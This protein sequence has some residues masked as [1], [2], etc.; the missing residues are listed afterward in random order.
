MWN[1]FSSAK[2]ALIRKGTEQALEPLEKQIG[3]LVAE[4]KAQPLKGW[5]TILVNFVIVAGTA[6]VSF[7]AGLDLE[8]DLGLTPTIATVGMAVINSIL[9]AITTGPVGSKL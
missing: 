9:R 7:L 4:Q 6:G 5:R 1:P 8:K 2:N 3:G